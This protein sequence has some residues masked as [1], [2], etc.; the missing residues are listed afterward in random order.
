MPMQTAAYHYAA[1]S[2]GKIA[3]WT[4]AELGIDFEPVL[5]DMR[6]GDHKSEWFLK[7]NP[8]GKAR[9]PPTL[10]PPL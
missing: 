8:F 9:V 7:I 10:E 5:L 6:A 4:A 1:G 3:E 2:R